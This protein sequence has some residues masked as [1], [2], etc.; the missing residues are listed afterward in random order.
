MN[1][2]A[3]LHEILD[4]LRN[5]FFGK[6]RGTVTDVDASTM[7]VKAYVP[8]V[9]G[10]QASGWCQPCVPYAGPNV[11]FCM[12]PEVGSGVWI[13][14]EAGDVSRPIWVGCFWY[15]TEV[16]ST[17]DPEI[18]QI[19]TTAGTLAFSDSAS[20]ITVT[21]AQNQTVLL[22]TQGITLTAGS[23]AVAVGASGVN[24]NSGALVVT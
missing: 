15:S 8:A 6:Y 21:G 18:R 12:L 10:D 16:P 19:I 5:R 23:G 1:D 24:V 14:F 7:S 20:N 17:A 4:R 11:G 22:D 13:E 2:Q 9:L 3:Q